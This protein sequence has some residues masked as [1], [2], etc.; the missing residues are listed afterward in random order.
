MSKLDE[1]RQAKKETVS[2]P[3]KQS[4][5]EKQAYINVVSFSGNTG[6][7]AEFVTTTTGKELVKSSLAVWQ[8][9]K[10]APSMWFD[11]VVWIDENKQEVA[12]ALLAQAKGSPIVVEG[13]LTMRLYQ[14]KPYYTINVT[15]VS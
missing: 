7:D 1:A 13:R 6:K 4:E 2:T 12:E 8:P 15:K 9:G 11:L 10:D 3:I 5:A 14:E